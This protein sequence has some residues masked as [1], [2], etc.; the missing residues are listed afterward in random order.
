MHHSCHLCRH[1]ITHAGCSSGLDVDKGHRRLVYALS[2]SD[3]D[4]V[5]Y[6]YMSF[7]LLSVHV[8][9]CILIQSCHFSCYQCMSAIACKSFRFQLRG[10]INSVTCNLRHPILTKACVDE[11]GM[12]GLR[13][14]AGCDR[15]TAEYLAWRCLSKRKPC[16]WLHTGVIESCT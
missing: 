12:K 11:E 4:A 6:C 2:N 10:F 9:V 5:I 16:H 7:Q 15:P 13:T 14:L 8:V 3:S 1:Y